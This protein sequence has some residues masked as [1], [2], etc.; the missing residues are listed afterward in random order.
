[1][2]TRTLDSGGPQQEASHGNPAAH[3]HRGRA[4][5]HPGRYCDGGGLYLNVTPAGTRSWEFR[6]TQLGRTRYLGLGSLNDV[7]LAEARER[8]REAR[9]IHRAGRDPVAQS[10]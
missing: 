6:Y 3:R 4:H 5:P 7:T 10:R 9:I 1:V 8:A 2:R